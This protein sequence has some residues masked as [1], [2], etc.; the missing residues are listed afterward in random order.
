MWGAGGG[1]VDASS[2]NPAKGGGGGYS[3][4]RFQFEHQKPYHLIV[5]QGGWNQ[6]SSIVDVYTIGGG[7]STNVS[8]G[9]R[10]GGGFTG[11]FSGSQNQSNAIIVA[12]GGGGGTTYEAGPYAFH[13]GSGGGSAGER[14]HGYN[15]DTGQG[16]DNYFG[17]GGTQTSGGA[18]ALGTA[19]DG[20]SLRGGH[21]ANGSA[22]TPAGG[23]GGYFG[24]GGSGGTPPS[25][26]S[27]GVRGS[28]GGGSGYLR[29]T[30]ANGVLTTGIGP[31]PGN[32]SDGHR[33]GAGSG[34][35]T[36]SF[37]TGS[38]GRVVIL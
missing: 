11:L 35:T 13:G 1:G 12:G 14:G 9:C 31:I 34:G 25:S 17:Y 20:S 21:G 38:S 5:G 18:G 8:S 26:P 27:H 28:A 15:L 3:S 6:V 36:S 19:D 4:G 10:V 7:A 16:S 23:G 29:S 2:G 37:T 22:G 32:S 30:V 33:Q 24:G